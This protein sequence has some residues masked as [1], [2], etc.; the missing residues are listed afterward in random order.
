MCFHWCMFAKQNSTHLFWNQGGFLKKTINRIQL[1]FCGMQRGPNLH[2]H[3]ATGHSSKPPKERKPHGLRT[4]FFDPFS[5][6]QFKIQ[7][8]KTQSNPGAVGFS[9][10]KWCFPFPGGVG[11]PPEHFSFPGVFRSRNRVFCSS[12]V[13]RSHTLRCFPC[14]R[15]CFSGTERCFVGPLVFIVPRKVCIVPSVPS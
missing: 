15:W 9:F 13:F 7:K 10:P 8:T 11:F 1:P 12:G 2:A 4:L 5:H 6:G 3:P 14:P